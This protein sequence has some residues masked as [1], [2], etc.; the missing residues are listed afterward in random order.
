MHKLVLP[1]A[2]AAGLLA[3]CATDGGGEGDDPLEPANRRFHS[4]NNAFD[5]LI[6]R[7]LA[8][9]YV[10]ITT[11]WMRE[12]VTNFFDNVAYPNVI[13]NDFLQGKIEQGFEDTMRLIFNST[14]GL[15]GLVDFVGPIGLPAHD[16][17]FGQTLAVW[18]IEEIA[19]LELP[20]LGPNS[21]RDVP[22]VPVSTA[23]NLMQF[24]NSDLIA[25][26][27]FALNVINSRANLSS[28]IA[29][30]DRSALDPYVFTREAYRQRREFLIY[31]G[32]PPEEAFDKLEQSSGIF[33]GIPLPGTG[34]GTAALGPDVG[35]AA[36]V[37]A[38]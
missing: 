35:A 26:P 3:G 16:E 12:G 17:D 13:L 27:L 25:W 8:E 4:F 30:R 22:D 37:P 2:L 33:E 32:E 11:D 38:S 20:L 18:G 34:R 9:T 1:L 19:Y 7:P 5:D 36:P 29:L 23:M 14:F 21:V 15:G 6:L 24:V 31:D 10:S 28:A